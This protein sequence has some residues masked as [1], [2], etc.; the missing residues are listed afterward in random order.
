M[1]DQ[2]M[3][4]A[5]GQQTFGRLVPVQVQQL[6]K[7]LRLLRVFEE[8]L[9]AQLHLARLAIEQRHATEGKLFGAEI[10]VRQADIAIDHPA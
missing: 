7:A 4:D 10:Q 8:G 1:T 2:F 6:P 5:A 9:L 3:G